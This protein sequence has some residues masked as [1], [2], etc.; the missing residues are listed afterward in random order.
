[1]L[2]I[3]LFLTEIY[4]RMNYNTKNIQTI[5]KLKSELDELIPFSE[6]N[7]NKLQKKIRLEFN[8]NS[9]HLEGNTL[10]YGQTQLL[11]YF[12]K[13]S[14]DVSVSDIEE[15]KAHDVALS[16]ILDMAKDSERPL[17]EMFIKELNEIILV[18]PFWKDAISP[19]GTPVRKKIEIGQ[20]KTSPNS[21]RLKNGEIHEYASPE[22]TP[23]LVRDLINWYNE[24]KDALHPVQLAA[25]FHY[26]FVCIHPFDDG[27]GRVSRLLM[28]YIL[29]KYDYPMVIIKSE[30]KESY[31]TALQKADTGDLNSFIEY[32]E[33]QAIASLKLYIKAGK[34]EDI[35]EFGDIE[36]QIE[37][38]KREKLTQTKI[39]KTPKVSY[40]L[41]N[42]IHNDLWSPLNKLLNK[43]NDF[44]AE[45]SDAIYVDHFK[46]HKT[47]TV[48]SPI[49][50]A[51]RMFA[52][53][54]VEI[55][56]FEIF[57]KDLEE[58]D[59]S[60][61]RWTKKMLS[62]KSATKKMDYEIS[63]SLDLEESAYVLKIAESNANGDG[64]MK[65]TTILFEVE[66]E[67]KSYFMDEMIKGIQNRVSKHLISVI[68]KDI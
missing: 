51:A 10:T 61:V 65:N 12:D 66:N 2:K 52:D 8:Y 53:K 27:N 62:L 19:N 13:S 32:V 6:E 28:N 56:Q 59:V 68:E 44:F 11:L 67:Y 41:I 43:F 39:F 26:K 35:E 22:E 50:G 5:I 1:M 23:A 24:K 46:Y 9:N 20:Y 21:V 60:N 14:G 34:G 58:E 47:K 49:L 36:K 3:Y 18:K 7:K 4:A 33:E 15:M 48:Y 31:L 38:L 57:G 42:H 16:L 30:D 37:I 40:D 54:E 29:L 63:C 64:I 55:K 17:S 45:T 25:E